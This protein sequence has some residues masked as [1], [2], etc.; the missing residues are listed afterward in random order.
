MA[1]AQTWN[2]DFTFKGSS[3]LVFGTGAIT[4]GLAPK[5]T[6]VS[7]GFGAN[8]DLLTVS[9]AIGSGANNYGFTK[10]GAGE[11]LL[12]GSNAFGTATGASIIL[13]Q[14]TLG[15]GANSATALGN[16][17]NTLVIRGNDGLVGLDA[18]ATATLGAYKESWLT[19]FAFFGTAA[20]N[21]GS[22]AVTLGQTVQI[23]NLNSTNALT[24]GGSIG[25]SGSGFGLTANGPGILALTGADTYTGATTVN[26][27]ST[28]N[29][30]ASGANGSI[31]ATGGL[32]LNGGTFAYTRTGTNTQALG[33][34]TLNS[35]ASAIT[36]SLAT[37]TLTL[38]SITRNAGG[39][40]NFQGS[41]VMSYTGG[42]PSTILTSAT[43]SGICHGGGDGLGGRECCGH[44]D[45]W[46]FAGWR[47]VLLSQ[48]GDNT[49]RK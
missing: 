30:G 15:F 4:L 32:F 24:I 14:G 16:I 39:T 6:V 10:T 31:V 13:D 29:L 22:A 8:T 40:V 41:G 26:A 36:T 48:H 17:A 19:N 1:N 18:S 27:G 35:G 25:D 45:R 49:G 38:D 43:G 21:T 44:G 2:S 7:P 37:Q 47:D 34:L 28:L 46:R 11:L 23:T 33:A 20:L 5:L 3:P 42:T 9:S 12:T